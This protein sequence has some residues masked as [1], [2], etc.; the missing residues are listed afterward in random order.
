MIKH[1][2]LIALFSLSLRADV[3]MLFESPE[4]VMAGDEVMP[5]ILLHLANGLAL[6]F[7]DIVAMG[8]FYGLPG[9]PISQ[10][11]NEQER[12][13]RFIAAFNTLA[14]SKDST[15]ETT[16]IVSAI[17][18][19]R[20][21][22]A[23]ELAKGRSGQEVYSES[24][25]ERVM[26][27]NCITGGACSGPVWFL[28][29]GR[30]LLLAKTDYDH[31]GNNAVIA[32][33]TGHQVAIQ[34]AVKASARHDQKGLERAYAMEA[35]A[36]HFLT[37]RFSSGHMRTP[38]T[39]LP[40]HVT[41]SLVGSLLAIFM[42]NEDS[43][44]GLHVHNAQGDKWLAYGDAYYL[45]PRNKDNLVMTRKTLQLSIGEVNE[46]FVTGKMPAVFK[47]L[48][49]IPQVDENGV[50]ANLDI[51]ALFYFDSSSQKLMRRS[52]LSDP[53]DHHWTSNWLGWSTLAKLKALQGDENIPA[54]GE[55]E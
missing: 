36:C 17:H 7:G 26:N 53:Y 44:Y 16:K 5:N 43:A 33:L 51:A 46:A 35:F 54:Y 19:E 25:T 48:A 42:H 18:L 8:D 34:E 21:M 23:D 22:V 32:Y 4:H 52:N 6:S 38:R 3:H 39:E 27:W 31:F 45:D 2:L 14:A 1:C 41:P 10:G 15:E 30:Y 40:D 47:T 28:M 24:S 49:L 37:D 9:S 55:Y 13:M 11:L 50:D 29:P 20:K 12:K